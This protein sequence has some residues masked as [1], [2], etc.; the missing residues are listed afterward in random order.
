MRRKGLKRRPFLRPPTL[1]ESDLTDN[2]SYMAIIA[3]RRFA[4]KTPLTC[5]V[6]DDPDH[7]RH[8]HLASVAALRLLIGFV[9]EH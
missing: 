3:L 7:F 2:L 1:L 8:N 9:Q 5:S 6:L 4:P